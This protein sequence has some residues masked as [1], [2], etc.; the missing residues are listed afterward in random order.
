MKLLLAF[1][2]VGLTAGS[3]LA[4]ATLPDSRPAAAVSAMPP[5]LRS[6]AASDLQV[7]V[8]GSTRYLRLSATSWNGGSGRLLLLAGETDNASGKQKVYQRVFN[9]DGSYQQYLA[10]EFVWH[11]THNHTHFDDY[12]KY[13]LRPV[14]GPAS[15]RASSKVSF[16]IIDTSAVDLGLPG[17]PPNPQFQDCGATT[18]GLSVGWGDTYP[19]TLPGQEIDITGLANG[20]YTLTTLFDPL[21][22]IVE[23]D[24]TNNARTIVIRLTN[25]SV[26]VVDTN[27]TSTPTPTSTST[28]T[29]TA[30]ATPTPT[31]IVCSATDPDTDLDGACDALD[32]CPDIPNPDQRNLDA[33]NVTNDLAGADGLGDAC[34][35]DTDGD[36]YTDSAEAAMNPAKDP[37]SYCAIMRA[38]VDGDG[39]VSILDISTSAAR[40]TQ[41]IPPAP[42]RLAQDA[43][44]LIS[45]L[46]LSR[47]AAEFTTSIAAC[48]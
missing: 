16:C 14:S 33:G 41:S 23:S 45:I 42:E 7:T 47:M 17:A 39:L 46:D 13:T 18:Q 36:G 43:D 3:L 26:S 19:W 5:D 37:L 24:D 4:V 30:T 32:N 9:D 48:L 2:I 6:L 25:N 21:N 11:P 38:D 44:A 40:F 22:R 35:D 20:D 1:A 10:G 31:P 29:A 28:A 12:A 34:D 8:S 27:P 15:E